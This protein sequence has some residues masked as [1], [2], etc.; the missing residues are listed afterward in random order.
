[1]NL[2]LRIM[3]KTRHKKIS[4]ATIFSLA[5]CFLIF[6]SPVH[7]QTAPQQSLSVSPIINDLHLTPGKKT[8]FTLSIENISQSPVGIHAEIDGMD[9]LG[10]TPIA[11][12]KLSAML[13]WTN[14]S[15]TDLLLGQKEKKTIL[16]TINTP[17]HIGQS[18]Y[19]E[20][21]FLT[22]ILHQEQVAW[23]PIILS[24]V[25]VLVLGTVGNLNYNDL[26]K[27]VSIA[28]ITPSE[29]IINSFPKTI[30]FTTANSYFSHFDAKPFITITPLFANSQTILLSDKHVLPGSART[31]QYQPTVPTN[32][33][34]YQIHLAVS[35]GDGKQ[36]TADTWFVV[37]PYKPTL[38]LILIAVLLYIGLAKRSRLGKF[39]KILVKG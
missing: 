29:K 27:K 13:N 18:G 8:S 19:Y 17:K 1:M 33:L 15:S 28:T 32:H 37:L 6:A 5:S 22:P 14:L 2:E 4:A 16:V 10:D 36:I 34:F 25:G 11:S 30:S 21:I 35:I 3:E 26:A 39:T 24:R 7:A 9:A 20:T 23:S 12:Q 31:W 38:L